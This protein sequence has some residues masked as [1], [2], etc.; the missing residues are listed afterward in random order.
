M[1]IQ[2]D[3][4]RSDAIGQYLV[5]SLGKL[6]ES[7]VDT[8]KET[9][10]LRAVGSAGSSPYSAESTVETSPSGPV[11]LT[12]LTK[13]LTV[14]ALE[15]PLGSLRAHRP[16][17]AVPPASARISWAC[18]PHAAPRTWNHSPLSSDT[19]SLLFDHV[20][21]PRHHFPSFFSSHPTRL[22][23]LILCVSAPFPKDSVI[24]PLIW[25]STG[26]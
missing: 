7:S 11:S 2:R 21:L 19:F 24:T 5:L 4:L 25:G 20:W 15:I 16:R 9:P 17:C 26:T 8:P 10:A 6:P 12:V 22:V 3:G 18:L 23:E 14:R 1:I 13:S